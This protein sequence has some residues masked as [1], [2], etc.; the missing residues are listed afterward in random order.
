MWF[1]EQL[2]LNFSF[3]NLIEIIK[4]VH[5]QDV[6]LFRCVAINEAGVSGHQARIS[7]IGVPYAQPIADITAVVGQPVVI[8]CAYSGYPIEEVY[9][10][11]SKR[12][13]PYD[14]RHSVASLGVITISQVDKSDEDE[15]SCVVVGENGQRSEQSFRVHVVSP[16]V[17]SPFLF[18]DA[19]EEGTRATAICSV[20]S[21]DPPIT[22]QWLKDGQPLLTGSTRV[23]PHI[24][25]LNI[26]EFISSLI[27][28]N[29]TR[30]HRG[31]YTCLAT[32]PNTSTNC[33]ARMEVKAP[34]KWLIK[35]SNH[36]A[37][38]QPNSVKLIKDSEQ[39]TT[40][41][42]SSVRFDCLASGNPTPVIRWKYLRFKYHTDK[43]DPSQY[44]V[45]PILSSPQIHVLENGSLLIRNLDKSKYEGVYLCEVSNGVGKV[46]EA[47]ASLV[48][49]TVPQLAVKIL[50]HN[51]NE[52]NG[53]GGSHHS[54][55]INDNNS[56]INLS[57]RRH[58]QVSLSC[59]GTGSVPL[60]INWFKDGHEI[61]AFDIGSVT[62]TSSFRLFE[63]KPKQVSFTNRSVEF[64]ERVAS[65]LL[66]HIGRS[67]SARY[68]CMGRN[69]YG[70][71]IRTVNLRVLEP[72]DSPEQLKAIE[73]GS[74]TVTLTW[75]V[76]YT[77]NLPLL[78]QNIEYKKESGRKYGT[79]MSQF[80]FPHSLL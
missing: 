64:G 21:G 24:Q 23:D 78:S 47:K 68:V 22:L 4:I 5:L 66:K 54:M 6:G 18:S 2:S 45:I 40:G 34:P 55:P 27:I 62:S 50:P 14:E 43:H 76:P 8:T 16:P 10:V 25:V 37:I 46:L 56:V 67:D 28:T 72:P 7:M 1:V 65:L 42:T 33:T 57:L 74:R 19:L 20:I 31:V 9:F 75:S 71:T 60:S 69:S 30:R 41:I 53:N 51:N 13:L 63:K 32:T 77:G 29:I 17:L 73:V 61:N 48:I 80:D 35:P 52:V 11:K 44:D 12:R 49:H 59:T 39:V 38:T 70:S 58:S 79:F 36:I 3:K 26:K 15:Y